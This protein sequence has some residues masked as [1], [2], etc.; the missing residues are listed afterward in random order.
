MTRAGVFLAFL[1]LAT[2][3]AAPAAG[4]SRA[5]TNRIIS[6]N[7]GVVI[8]MERVQLESAAAGGA[9]V[10]GVVGALRARG[11][12]SGS[13]ARSAAAGAAIGGVA[14]RILEG[15]N[16]AMEYKVRLNS[17]R[18]VRIITE[19]TGTRI[20]DCVSVEQGRQANIRRVSSVHCEMMDAEPTP[21]LTSE[22][23]ACEQAKQQLLDAEDEQALELAIRRV[24][25]L[26]ED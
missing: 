3:V 19:P 24:R 25:I 13:R 23:T 18:D 2:L 9:L 21:A 17:G 8:G 4:Q 1:G 16:E 22:A 5:D 20:G 7:Y 15:S 14:T 11:R 6:V 12:S 26:C 10:G